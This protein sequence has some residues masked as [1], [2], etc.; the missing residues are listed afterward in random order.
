MLTAILI[1]SAAVLTITW[2]IFDKGFASLTLSR[3]NDLIFE[4]KNKSY[5]A[6][7][8]RRQYDRNLVISLCAA[9]GAAGLLCFATAISTG[10]NSEGVS[11]P[12][13]HTTIFT[14]VP[15]K[16]LPKSATEPMQSKPETKP[17]G[18]S[19]PD[20]EPVVVT[21]PL[22]PIMT[23]ASNPPGPA[24]PLAGVGPGTSGPATGGGTVT[25]PGL[26]LEGHQ[27]DENAEFPGGMEALMKYLSSHIRYPETESDLGIS[28][29]V[30]LSFIVSSNGEITEVKELQG[31]K[32]GP[33]LSREA[34]RVIKSMPRW[35]PGKAHGREVSVVYRMPVRFTLK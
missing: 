33:N 10:S 34:I 35:K 1:A 3:Y 23:P 6:Y 20:T 19:K 18:I 27:V 32:G 2:A 12:T 29:I 13:T 26:P 31:V 25:D 5:G 15:E 8:L 9:T 7:I 30:Y 21:K 22:T 17:A 14:F 28:G 24:G 4:N 16:E 11:I